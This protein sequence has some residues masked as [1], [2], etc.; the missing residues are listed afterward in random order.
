ME[1]AVDDAKV[2]IGAATSDSG[3]VMAL[4]TQFH[5]DVL[6]YL[7]R[8]HSEVES[9]AKSCSSLSKLRKHCSNKTYPASL[10]SIKSPSI[11]FSHAFTNALVAEGHRGAYS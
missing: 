10:S 9:L 2:K 5:S 7:K 3:V 4:P 8:Y 6:E 11:Q 1:R